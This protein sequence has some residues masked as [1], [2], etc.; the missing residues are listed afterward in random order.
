MTNEKIC[1]E[2]ENRR[3]IMGFDDDQGIVPVVCPDCID[4][5]SDF[6]KLNGA[7]DEELNFEQE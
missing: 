1:A 2:C 5:W 4:D 6:E 3:V 7:G